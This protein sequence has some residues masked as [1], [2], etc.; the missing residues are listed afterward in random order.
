M[1]EEGAHQTGNTP[2]LASQFVVPD[3]KIGIIV[4][5]LSKMSCFASLILIKLKLLVNGVTLIFRGA[6]LSRSGHV[7][8]SVS[9]SLSQ[10]VTQSVTDVLD[11]L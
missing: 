1:R 8:Q 5:N 10:S 9:Q 11:K 2:T 7:T 3:Y 6:C 4:V